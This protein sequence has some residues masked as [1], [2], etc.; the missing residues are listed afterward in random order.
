MLGR[1]VEAAQETI[2]ICKDK[3]VLR[4][5]LAAHEKEVV[6]IMMALYDKEKLWDGLVWR[7][8]VLLAAPPASKT[9]TEALSGAF[10][11]FGSL[12]KTGCKIST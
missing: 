2:R 4:E 7:Y 11:F 5:Y 10:F 6:S 1:T 12:I 9:D 8:P 3:D